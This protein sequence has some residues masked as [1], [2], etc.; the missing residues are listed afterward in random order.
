[1][2]RIE[3]DGATL[4]QSTVVDINDLKRAEEQIRFHAYHDVLTCLP[5]RQLFRDRVRIGIAH[6]RRSQRN[7]AVMFIDLDDF[8]KLNDTLGH[9]FG[10]EALVLMAERLASVLRKG[11][12]LARPGGDEFQI[13]IADVVS[14]ADVERIARK[15]LHTIAKPLAIGTREIFLT[16]S[17]GIALF[18]ADGVDEES[19]MKSADSA[20][21]EAKQMGRNTYRVSTI[22]LNRRATE[23]F[24][25]ENSLRTSVESGDFLIHYQPIV[26]AFDRRF[27]ALEALVR[28][29]HPERGLLLPIDFIRIA[30]ETGLIVPLG[31]W[32]LQRACIDA[33]AWQRRGMDGV[34]VAVNISQ[35]Q[36]QRAEFAT[37]VNRILAETGLRPDLL[38]LEITESV[39][40]QD[41]DATSVLLRGLRDAGVR[42]SIDDIGTGYSSLA[43]L[44]QFPVS[45]VKVD[46]AFVSNVTTDRSDA[47]IVAAVIGVA[48]SLEMEVIAEGVET[49]EQAVFLRQNHCNLLQGYL[50]G[51]PMAIEDWL[52]PSAET[53]LIS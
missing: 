52:L 41:P 6:A 18:P 24:I 44:K 4:F 48:H 19:L 2:S 50:Y 30:E 46:K 36:L 13:L 11:D 34:R 21:F 7:A 8:K 23:R 53:A 27:I 14:T 16:A 49:E 35:K 37:T 40:A 33:V 12:T 25:V 26:D 3:I 31:D 15:L 29:Q 20:L 32:V 9:T 5:N 1:V 22:E 10:D 45:T 17:I 43:Y 42:V 47:A 28:W 39:A 38:E 51:E